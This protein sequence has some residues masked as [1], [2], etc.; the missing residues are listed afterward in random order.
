M[1]TVQSL[2]SK[3]L[4]NPPKW[5]PD[6]IMYETITGSVAYAISNDTSDMDF[7]GWCIPPRKDVLREGEIPGFGRQIQRFEQFIDHGI[8]DPS[9][10]GGKGR[11]YDI[12][13]FSVVKYFQL[14]MDNN[15]NMIDTLYT[16]YECILHSTELGKLVRDN[17]NIFLHKGCFH[18]FLGYAHSMCHKMSNKTEQKNDIQ[19][20]LNKLDDSCD[21]SLE[22]IEKELLRRSNLK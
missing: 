15:P 9:A 7:Y 16:P 8:E 14:C 4:I 2:L 1:N 12:T 22:A 13:I 21:I 10:M 19:L 6:N 3:K 20:I 5:L 11:V 18:K 17:A